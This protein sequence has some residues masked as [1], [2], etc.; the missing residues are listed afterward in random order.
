MCNALHLYSRASTSTILLFSLLLLLLDSSIVFPLPPQFYCFPS[1]STILLFSLLFHNSIVFPPPSQFYCFPSSSTI[2]IHQC[3]FLFRTATPQQVH[4][5][6][7]VY[8]ICLSNTSLF[9]KKIDR[10]CFHTRM[11]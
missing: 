9:P 6:V 7:P 5:L 4:V 2:P 11:L 8:T 3:E 10:N 1:S